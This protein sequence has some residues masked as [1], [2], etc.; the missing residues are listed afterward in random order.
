MIVEVRPEKKLAQ[1][2]SPNSA[3]ASRQVCRP[4]AELAVKFVGW[5]QLKNSYLRWIFADIRELADKFVGLVLSKPTN[6]LASSRLF[7]F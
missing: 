3:Q 2:F 5:L 1:F 4:S 6:L 7:L